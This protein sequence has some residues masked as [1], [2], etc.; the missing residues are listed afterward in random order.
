VAALLA[1]GL[2][3]WTLRRT[4]RAI[5]RWFDRAVLRTVHQFQVR[6]NRQKLV[7]KRSMREALLA[8]PDVVEAMRQQCR[9]ESM[10]EADARARVEDYI[11]EIVPYFNVL[12][13]YKLGYNIARLFIPMLYRA[14][15]TYLDRKALSSIPRDDIVLYLMNH[16]SNADYVV[17]AYVLARA[18]SISYA[19]GEWA[20]V[21]PLEYVF[22]S[23]GAYF[24][25]RGFRDPLYHTVLR[26]YVQIITLN[27]I[28]Q[29]IFLEGGL[30]RDGRLR[31]AKVGLLDYITRSVPELGAE[32]DIWLVPVA[33]NYDRVLEDRSLTLEISAGV[34]RPGRLRQFS[35][36]L[37][38]VLFN[39]GRLLTGNLRRYGRVQVN[40]GRPMSLHSW[41]EHNDGVLDLPKEQ[42]LPQ[43]QKLAN[44]VMGH[45]ATIM[46][47][48]PVPLVAAAFLSF[49]ETVVRRDHLLER[50]ESF[51]DDLIR[52]RA[53]LVQPERSADEIL[54]RAWRMLS[55]RRLVVRHGDGYVL[56]PRQRPLLE[57]YANSVKH[58]LPAVE[59]E[60]VMHPAREPDS[61][62]PRLSPWS[63]SGGHTSGTGRDSAS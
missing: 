3:L 1:G 36:V 5:Q 24:V 11:D 42:R 15:S 20:R 27:G 13:Y 4:R 33:L 8:D 47:V 39:I 32:R 29:G 6:L 21:W 59:F 26:R 19:V 12:S 51:R 30:S 25:R 14:D 50:I 31:P 43:L 62:L 34:P 23:F 37:H 38:Y 40:F 16:R 54:D 52:S 48:T 61:T 2:T 17:A 44:E 57:Y 18:V 63:S 53:Q 56:L 35:T 22:K 60:P 45:V 41:L 10:S 55:M 58:L 28:T 49:Q 46:P 9:T 7:S